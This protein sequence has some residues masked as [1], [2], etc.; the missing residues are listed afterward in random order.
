MSKLSNADLPLFFDAHHHEL[1]DHLGPVAAALEGD[2]DAAAVA[3]AMGETHDLY[4][5]L[6]PETGATDVRALC[7]IREALGYANPMADSIFAVQGLGSYPIAMGGSDAQ[8]ALLHDVRSGSRIGG[9]GLTE[10]GA[11]SDVKA[12]STTATAT[13]AGF[14]LNGEKTFISNVGI[15][16]HFVVFA[17]LEGAITAFLVPADAC[18]R[19][20]IEMSVDHPIGRL[21]FEDARVD[22]DAIIGAPGQGMK[23]AL[24]TL[25]TFR[26]SVAAAA[27]G[28]ARRA[29]TEA[30]AHVKKR[31]QFGQPLA[32]QQTVQ[33][34]LADMATELDAARL[35]VLRAAHGLDTT[36]GRCSKEVSMAKLFATEAAQR[37]IDKA[38]QLHG[39]LGV[40]R[41]S[42]V[43]ALYREI[44]PLRIY[45]GTTEIQRL[46]I[47]REL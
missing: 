43:E 17:R 35:L 8:K 29:L 18:R 45:E 23:L 15:A 31:V 40:T 16:H 6:V 36:G 19:E 41:G 14:E 25:G 33:G 30:L 1:A 37:I 34:Y 5:W 46:I 11:G 7:L 13:A 9:F 27:V 10:P 21:L 44:R 20:P 28:M 26:V 47:A 32:A 42:V 4:R 3:R 2:H 12:M 24:G 39:G 38:V 22:R